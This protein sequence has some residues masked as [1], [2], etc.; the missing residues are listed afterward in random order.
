VNSQPATPAG[1]PA[2]SFVKGPQGQDLLV[3]A[4]D[5][6]GNISI[7][8]PTLKA[9]VSLVNCGCAGQFSLYHDPFN[10]ATYF[11][12]PLIGASS[13]IFGLTQ[14]LQLA[15]PIT[16]APITVGSDA[17][18][19]LPTFSW[20]LLAVAL[21]SDGAFVTPAF[22]QMATLRF[23]FP[24]APIEYIFTSTETNVYDIQSAAAVLSAPI[25]VGSVSQDGKSIYGWTF[26]TTYYDPSVLPTAGTPNAAGVP[27][28]G[29]CYENFPAL[30]VANQYVCILPTGLTRYQLG[31]SGSPSFT[32]TAAFSMPASTSVFP[33]SVFDEQYAYLEWVSIDSGGFPTGPYYI[34]K[35]DPGTLQPAPNDNPILMLGPTGGVPTSSF[36]VGA[37]TY[38]GTSP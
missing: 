26:S 5:S 31:S 34:H 10:Q 32:A 7:D 15:A 2:F 24:P 18:L 21:G 37:Y 20:N 35:A 38:T 6:Q 23:L 1:F 11:Y 13:Q 16:W 28:D 4:P 29:G 19:T 33:P 25:N 9:S 3:A 14:N 12:N 27:P 8:D 17:P 22:T 30:P 36:V